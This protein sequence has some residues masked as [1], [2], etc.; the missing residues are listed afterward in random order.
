MQHN[1]MAYATY[2]PI[3]WHMQP[4]T[5]DPIH[6]YQ[7]HYSMFALLMRSRKIDEVCD[8]YL[9]SIRLSNKAVLNV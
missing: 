1:S 6:T 7:V 8:I 2:Q 4:I 9:V 5:T 3:R